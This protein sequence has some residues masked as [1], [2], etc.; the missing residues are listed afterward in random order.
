LLAADEISKLPTT[1]VPY[2]PTPLTPTSNYTF[3]I[4]TTKASPES[5]RIHPVSPANNI[6][7]TSATC[8][9][10]NECKT[11]TT[12]RATD[13]SSNLIRSTQKVLTQ[14]HALSLMQ[15]SGNRNLIKKYIFMY[16][17]SRKKKKQRYN[18]KL[19]WRTEEAM[20]NLCYILLASKES[21]PGRGRRE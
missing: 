11:N 1:P 18:Q 16:I 15:V 17:S 13:H 8:N 4:D 12:T 2:P 7:P 10:V 5:D 19:Y 3:Y 9:I 14:C 20:E 21:N 6:T